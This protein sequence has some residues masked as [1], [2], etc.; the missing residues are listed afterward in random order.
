MPD[1]FTSDPRTDSAVALVVASNNALGA[2]A[3][4][5]ANIPFTQ[6]SEAAGLPANSPKQQVTSGT[7][8]GTP[9]PS[10]TTA[11]CPVEKK[12]VAKLDGSSNKKLPTNC[13][14]CGYEKLTYS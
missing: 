8:A 14:R 7:V 2:T 9:N 11:T 10:Y 12:V 5:T 13:P 3:G 1:A 6:I 4:A